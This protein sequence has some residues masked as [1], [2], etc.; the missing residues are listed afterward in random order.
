MNRALRIHK[1]DVTTHQTTSGFLGKIAEFMNY[2][3]QAN[4]DMPDAAIDITKQILNKQNTA[5]KQPT[6]NWKA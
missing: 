5:I 4:P 3:L 1:Q 2:T 6:S